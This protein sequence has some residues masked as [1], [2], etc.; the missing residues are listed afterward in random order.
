MLGRRAHVPPPKR[1]TGLPP[2]AVFDFTAEET[3]NWQNVVKRVPDRESETG[4]TNRLE[5]SDKDM[6]KYKLP[7]PWGLYDTANKRSGGSGAIKPADVPGPGYH[8]YKMGTFRIAPSYYLY[9]FWSWIIQ[10]DIGGVIDPVDPDRP[11]D[12][13]AQIKFEGPGF[14][15]GRTDDKNAICVERVVLVKTK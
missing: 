12:I 2:G 14:P 1:F 15:H 4:T 6:A 11:F 10:V 8:W 13:W 5:L 7:M 3:R 9:F